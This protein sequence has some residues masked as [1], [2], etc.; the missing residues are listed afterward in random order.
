MEIDVVLVS[1]L[2]A[3]QFPEWANLPITAV[4][5]SGWDNRTF[6]LGNEMSVRLPSGEEYERQVEKE[7][8]WLPKIAPHLP[9]PIPAPIAM[10]MPSEIYPWNWSIYKWLDGVSANQ[11]ELTED[12]L[13]TIAAQLAQFLIAFHKFDADGAPAPGL[14][15]WWRAAHTS[16][17]DADTRMLMETL[18]DFVDVDKA[19]SLWESALN[20]KWNKDPVWVHG[21]V[22]SGNLL[23]KNNRLAAVID[24][25]CMGIGD[26]ACDLT[27]A[28]TFFKG[29]SRKIFKA[30]MHLDE[31]TWARARGWAMWKA[32]FEISQL[33]DKSGA[34]LV[35]QQQ[36]I[37]AVIEEGEKPNGNH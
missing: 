3:S 6:H 34:A 11:L 32:L 19:K 22:A 25:G 24:F 17:Y 20:S 13:V 16:V 1:K 2:I 21:D 18:K 30:N 4:A 14:H 26:P 10:G 35:K 37:D 7:Q 28:W 9:L 15:N 36:I 33:K 23:V 29:E 27:I 8:K 5:E 12:D 31:E